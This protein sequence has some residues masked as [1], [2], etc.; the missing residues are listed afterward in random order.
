MSAVREDGVETAA[1]DQNNV[2]MESN[3][4]TSEKKKLPKLVRPLPSP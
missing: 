2:D 4:S 1:A 3:K